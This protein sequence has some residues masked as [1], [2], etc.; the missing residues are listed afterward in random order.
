MKRKY[1]LNDYLRK[2]Y[3]EIWEKTPDNFPVLPDMYQVSLQKA[4]ERL[5]D[6]F[7]DEAIALVRKFPD[8]SGTDHA[9]WGSALKKLVYGFGTDVLGFG[10]S[11]MEM[12]L[13]GGFCDASSDFMEKARQFDAGLKLDDIFQALRNVWVMNCIQKLT[14]RKVEITPSVFA[15]SMLYPYTDNYLDCAHVPMRSKARMNSRIKKRLAGKEIAAGSA[16]EK[17]LFR[18]IELIEGQYDRDNCPL[19]YE[20]LLGIHSAQEESVRQN[21]RKPW[22]R[23]DVPGISIGKGGSSVLADAYLVKEDLSDEEASFFFRFRRGFAVPGRSAGC[24]R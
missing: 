7:T 23:P 9:Q 15:Y 24:V 2:K 17:K 6:E 16:L 10:E 18:L 20:S 11:T 22:S 13:N 8:I 1:G 19:V 12:L 4:K 14:G 21:I 5:A 3:I